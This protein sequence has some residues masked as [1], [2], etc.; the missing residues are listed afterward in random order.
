MV[1]VV[2]EAVVFTM[3]PMPMNFDDQVRERLREIKK[4]RK[5]SD[6]KIGA[7]LGQTPQAVNNYLRG[8][9]KSW[10]PD[11]IAGLEQK[12]GERIMPAL[13]SIG[14]RALSLS[15]GQNPSTPL[16][17]TNV[18]TD[19]VI[20]PRHWPAGLEGARLMEALSR[21]AT[22][23]TLVSHPD[24]EVFVVVSTRRIGSR[25]LPGDELWISPAT[26]PIEG[27]AVAVEVDGALEIA[28]Y[29][30]IDGRPVVRIAGRFVTAFRPVG[31]VVRAVINQ[32]PM[33]DSGN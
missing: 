5:I 32:I 4:R 20:D 7:M 33:F 6:A 10:P 15:V 13:D 30:R 2:E 23:R 26:P 25:V 16:E 9:T 21:I 17:L 29:G 3:A 31:S 8:V 14:P 22:Q 18:R 19:P 11:L 24:P 27:Q 1:G 12:L 28:E